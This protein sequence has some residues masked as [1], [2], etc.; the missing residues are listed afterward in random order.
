MDVKDKVIEV[1]IFRCSPCNVTF[2]VEDDFL[3][4]NFFCLEEN[5][6][7]DT[8]SKEFEFEAELLLHVNNDHLNRKSNNIANFDPEYSENSQCFTRPVNENTRCDKWNKQL[9]S[10]DDLRDLRNQTLNNPSDEKRF[11]CDYCE[12]RLS[13]KFALQTHMLRKHDDKRFAKYSCNFCEKKFLAKYYH[14]EHLLS[15]ESYDTVNEHFRC[16]Q[17]E[18]RYLTK[19][20]LKKHISIVHDK[21]KN[22]KCDI[23]GKAFNRKHH[24]KGHMKTV[25]S[26]EKKFACDYCDK[27]CK[28]RMG[29]K[30]HMLT[31]HNDHRFSKYSCNI[32]DKKFYVKSDYVNHISNHKK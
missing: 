1:K 25:H 11:D 9:S 3:K 14:D 7:C 22:F 2:L 27:K 21:T 24:M 6:K 13:S 28:T 19:N 32:C 5:N 20:A 31:L 17:C 26:D 8:C 16:D 23:C 10:K 4:H 12:K 15:H 29:V 30:Y 18:K